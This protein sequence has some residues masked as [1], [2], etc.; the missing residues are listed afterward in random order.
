MKYTDTADG[1]WVRPAAHG[2]R[3]ACCDCGLVHDIDIRIADFRGEG[4]VEFRATRNNRATA[5]R[6]RGRAKGLAA[7]AK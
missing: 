1:E 2:Y 5:A 7:L 6:R 3:V 4:V